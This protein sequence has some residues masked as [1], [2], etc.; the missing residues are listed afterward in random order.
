MQILTK[1]SL[2]L[3]FWGILGFMLSYLKFFEWFSINGFDIISGWQ[4]G[5]SASIFG[6]GFIL[7]LVACAFMVF[8]LFFMDRKKLGWVWSLLIVLSTLVFSVSIGLALY[9]IKIETLK[10]KV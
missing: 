2:T 7:D 5:F 4:E 9:L 3:L 1:R 6:T 8:V 10:R